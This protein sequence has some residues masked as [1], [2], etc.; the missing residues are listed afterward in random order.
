MSIKIDKKILSKSKSRPTKYVGQGETSVGTV[1]RKKPVFI[2]ATEKCR[3]KQPRRR[4]G[5]VVR[6]RHGDPRDAN[7]HTGPPW[8]HEKESR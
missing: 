2:P 7:K 6:R 1:Q 5:D 4:Y 3:Y 8:H